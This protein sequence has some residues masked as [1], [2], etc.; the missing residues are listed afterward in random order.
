MHKAVGAVVFA[1][2]LL[3]ALPSFAADDAKP[4][5]I[6]NVIKSGMPYGAGKMHVLFMTAYDASLWTDAARWSMQAPFALSITYHFACSTSDIADRL[7]NEI[8]HVDPG[9]SSA[10]LAHYRSLIAGIF[11][12]VKSGDHMTG[13]YTP[14]GTIRF[15]NDGQPL[16]QVHDASFA[17]AFFGI[18]FSPGTSEPGLRDK[19]LHLDT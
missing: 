7:L 3:A 1:G 5:E 15:Y 6:S 2:A 14:D 16:G 19:L 17:Q 11:P 9:L 4:A 18:W 13:L 10:T 12:D 8:S